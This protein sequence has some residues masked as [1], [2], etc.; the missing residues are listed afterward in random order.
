MGVTGCTL[1]DRNPENADDPKTRR[2]SKFH[3][4]GSHGCN[5]PAVYYNPFTH[6]FGEDDIL[7]PGV[8][9]MYLNQKP[10]NGHPVKGP[11]N[12][13]EDPMQSGKYL[14]GAKEVGIA[15]S[16]RMA[17]IS[18]STG[19]VWAKCTLYFCSDAKDYRC[20]TVSLSHC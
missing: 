10:V 13:D 9:G 12:R 6:R 17:L 7:V 11:D 8:N 4:V 16:D 14:S 1:Y 20:I 15:Y 19:E 18:F 3:L 5:Q 2:P